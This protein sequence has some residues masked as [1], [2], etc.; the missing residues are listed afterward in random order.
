M[1]PPRRQ[2]PLGQPRPP[3]TTLS[4]RARLRKQT[5][6]PGVVSCRRHCGCAWKIRIARCRH[7]RCASHASSSGHRRRVD[8]HRPSRPHLRGRWRP[9]R[10]QL[11]LRPPAHSV[12]RSSV[13]ARCRLVRHCQAGRGRCP[14]SRFDRRCRRVSARPI[15]RPT[16][17][18]AARLAWLVPADVRLASRVSRRR[19]LDSQAFSSVRVRRARDIGHRATSVHVPAAVAAAANVGVRKRPRC[20]QHRPLRRPSRA[21]SRSPRA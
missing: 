18:S 5:T 1:Q 12:R 13:L 15:S 2:P 14:R 8:Q 11:G 17:T 10:R 19:V 6:P 16:P 21:S 4:S 20:R 3:R 7:R 9:G